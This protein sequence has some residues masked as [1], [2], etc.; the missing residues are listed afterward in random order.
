MFAAARYDPVR[1]KDAGLIRDAVGKKPLYLRRL[2]GG[3]AFASTLVAL[4]AVSGPMQVREDAIREYLVFRSIGG[5][6]SAFNDVEQLPPGSWLEMGIDGY[7]QRGRW[8]QAPPPECDVDASIAEVRASIDEAVA[9]RAATGHKL[10]IFLSGGL[11]SA[12]VAES[13]LRQ[14][15][16]NP[17]HLVSIGY[18]VPGVEDERNYA[19]SLAQTFGHPIEELTLRAAQVPEIMDGAARLTEDPI[20]DPVT[21][22]TFLLAQAAAR[23]TK[24]VLTGDGSDEVWGGY[25]R[26]DNA[27]PS[28][29]EY[30]PRTAIF[31]PADLGLDGFPSTY[32]LSTEGVS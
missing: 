16:G 20:Q 12:I 22:P 14:R 17:V 27:P 9:A 10:A 29:E 31:Q 25:Q 32:H 21:L 13:A 3:W 30:L 1:G 18:D 15:R 6:R 2:P 7:C 26:F 4:H 11:D 8:W 28:I 23:H 24:V 19:R 5:N